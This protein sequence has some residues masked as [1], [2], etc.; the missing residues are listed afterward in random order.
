[1]KKILMMV[2]LMSGLVASG[3]QASP[4]K[5][6]IV[7]GV[8]EKSL[9]PN[10]LSLIV[11]VWSKAATAK[12]AQQLAATQFKQVKKTLDDFKIK[13]ED[14]QTDNYALNPEYEYD[15][16]LRQN[17]LVGFRVTHTLTVV[18]RKV[19]DAGNFLDAMIIEKKLA[20]SGVNLNS[21]NWDSDKR[22]LTETSALGDAV[23]A[24]K[25]K[26]DEMAK[27]A[28]VKLGSV[29]KMSHNT[30]A[31]GGGGPIFRNYALKS[32]EAAPATEMSAGQIKVR[33]EVNLEYEIH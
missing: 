8:A 27:A 9:D 1:M 2:V 31:G 12:Q 10:L 32:M 26:A 28:G 17:R 16:K 29:M 24:A 15:Q 7:N 33:A 5:L 19:E 14:V 3:V 6:I 20:D 21:I 4:E 30:S 22:S 25:V 23:R 11:E 13:K 18:L